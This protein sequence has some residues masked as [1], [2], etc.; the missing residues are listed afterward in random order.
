MKILVVYNPEST[1]ALLSAAYIKHWYK[2]KYKFGALYVDTQA[3]TKATST[4]AFKMYMV[5]ESA[6]VFLLGLSD[7]LALLDSWSRSDSPITII[8]Q[9][10]TRSNEY[11]RRLA[12]YQGIVYCPT[13]VRDHPVRSIGQVTQALFPN[14]Y[15][16][17]SE[18]GSITYGARNTSANVVSRFFD[19]PNMSWS[20]QRLAYELVSAQPFFRNRSVDEAVA[21]LDDCVAGQILDAINLP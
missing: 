18:L 11:V 1:E 9:Q 3:E 13:M 10:T 21:F 6:S 19:K 17:A 16:V 20:A 2:M 4:S 5:D 7:P 8:D 14:V 12:E 15:T